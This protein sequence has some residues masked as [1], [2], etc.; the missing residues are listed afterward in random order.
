MITVW[1]CSISTSFIAIGGV[2]APP[3][4]REISDFCD[5]FSFIDR[6]IVENLFTIQGTAQTTAPIL[7]LDG[8][9]D[10]FCHKEVPF[11]G[12][13]RQKSHFGGILPPKPPNFLP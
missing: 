3:Q 13:S 8:S 5:F 10:A 11:G 2:V 9:N 1:S 6:F 7:T 4:G 12:H